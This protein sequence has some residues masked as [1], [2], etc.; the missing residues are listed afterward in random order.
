MWDIWK[1]ECKEVCL[2]HNRLSIIDLSSDSNQ[3]MFSEDKNHVIIY[4]GEIYIYLELR[5]ELKKL[6]LAKD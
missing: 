2:G 6:T 5:D 4:N 3:P 1:A